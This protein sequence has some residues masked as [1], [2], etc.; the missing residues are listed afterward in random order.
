MTWAAGTSLKPGFPD[1]LSWGDRAGRDV[2]ANEPCPTGLRACSP[3][4]RPTTSRSRGSSCTQRMWSLWA[5]RAMKSPLGS[6]S[7]S[8]GV[9]T[10][11][12][13]PWGCPTYGESTLQRVVLQELGCVQG[14]GVRKA[15]GMGDKPWVFLPA[16]SILTVQEQDF[17]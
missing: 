6:M 5:G 15:G 12:L 10:S 11:S 17:P 3:L 1:G 16:L 13:L 7:P 9:P 14:M 2:P 4:H 8:V